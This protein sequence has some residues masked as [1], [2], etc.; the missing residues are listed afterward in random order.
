MT[1]S[2]IDSSCLMLGLINC[3]MTCI[4]STSNFLIAK[5]WQ[6]WIHL[7]ACTL[8][9]ANISAC[10]W[11]LNV[12]T[13]A[14]SESISNQ[15]SITCAREASAYICTGSVFMARVTVTFINIGTTITHKNTISSITIIAGTYI[16]PPTL[17]TCCN[18]CPKGRFTWLTSTIIS[19]KS[20][21]IKL[22]IPGINWPLN[23]V[24][25]IK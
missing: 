21:T 7:C 14:G 3:D 9:S 23:N 24:Q 1:K 25:T 17:W 11:L 20:N 2:Y 6:I 8:A 15:S 19:Y 10:I 5:K 12:L 13:F 22:M 16:C 4:W 18:S